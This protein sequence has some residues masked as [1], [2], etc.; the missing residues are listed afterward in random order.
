VHF[1][2]AVG[3]VQWEQQPRD[4]PLPGGKAVLHQVAFFLNAP[5]TTRSDNRLR[6]ARFF[7]EHLAVMF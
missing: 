6:N 7:H 4:A 5:V 3:C 1:G 2:S